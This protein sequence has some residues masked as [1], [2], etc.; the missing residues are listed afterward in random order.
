MTIRLKTLELQNFRSWKELN[1]TNLDSRGLTLIQGSNGSGKSSIRQAV[2]Y[3]LTDT[4][5]DSIPL[6]EFPREGNT[7]CKMYCKLEK[8]N[9]IIE[10]TKYRNSKKHKNDTILK[11]NGSDSFT[12][13]DRRDTQKEIDKLLDTSNLFMSTIFSQY[14][15]SFAEA[16]DSQRK[17]IL[18][19]FLDLGK[20][21]VF[22]DRAKE[23][24]NEIE[25]NINDNNIK[26]N[27]Y[28]KSIEELKEELKSYD[29]KIS[30]FDVEKRTKIA[31]L[32]LK[33]DN[34]K[35]KDTSDLESEIADL[36][37][38]RIIPNIEEYNTIEQNRK[39]LTK[40]RI[41]IQQEIKL[42]T[43]QLN[44]SENNIC[45][46]FKDEC[47]RLTEESNKV[48]EIYTPK[49]NKLNKK[50]TKLTL[51]LKDIETKI[52][53][54]E[55]EIEEDNK[56]VRQIQ[57]HEKE[58]ER[59]RYEN[60]NIEK[61]IISIDERIKEISAEQNPYEE[62]RQGINDKIDQTAGWIKD[63]KNEN[64]KL[65]DE[66]KYYEFW[67]KGFG[68]QGIPNL[69][70]EGMLGDLEDLIN[71]YLSQVSN[72]SV[73]LS[74]QSQLKSKESREKISYKV[75]DSSGRSRDYH[76][77][78]GGEKQRVR[79]ADMFAFHE[80][81]SDFNFLFLDEVLEGSLDGAGCDSVVDLLRLKSQD[82]GSIFVMSHSQIQDRF[83]NIINVEKSDGIST[84]VGAG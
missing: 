65:S 24:C 63:K 35:P 62:I 78:S 52:E 57:E 7:E 81:M 70:I 80:L 34:L 37:S 28:E 9:D 46:I 58:I 71:S 47:S 79:V 67:I 61:E 49:L 1:L 40:N 45:P 3:L 23:K 22:Q 41:E 69:K 76:S 77:F 50:N 6:E 2:E 16:K 20:Y 26:I 32:L 83:S 4:I 56:I 55:K 72:T 82:V 44:E 59:I 13:T 15:S 33:K 25:H 18:Y 14:S 42:I 51:K 66:Y 64:A 5:S 10:I 27:Y 39:E 19:K 30:N 54:Y 73:K 84:I 36:H 43:Q 74:A 12:H 31:E 8:D 60:V 53:K 38:N 21:D 68:K 75:I 29:N 11:L 48:K 17:D